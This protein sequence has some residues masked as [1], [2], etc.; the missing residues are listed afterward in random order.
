MARLTSLVLIASTAL[1][2]ALAAATKSCF[3]LHGTLDDGNE[4]NYVQSSATVADAGTQTAGFADSVKSASLFG[5]VDGDTDGRLVDY[6]DSGKVANI[7]AG[8]DFDPLFLDYATALNNYSLALKC[9]LDSSNVL[10][11]VAQ[12]DDS[13]SV[14]NWCEGYL[15][16]GSEVRTDF[17]CQGLK[18]VA[19]KATGCS[20]AS[21]TITS[22]SSSSTATETSS[23]ALD[24]IFKFSV[25]SP[26]AI[27]VSTL[28]NPTSSQQQHHQ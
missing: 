20:A 28:A 14:W 2:G 5:L 10:S 24:S 7:D 21:S 19:S 26:T 18:L 9:D 8:K 23:N 17:G 22:T 16:L 15:L 12:D 13:V 4:V 27:G 1:S 25:R 3:T 11:C 6:S